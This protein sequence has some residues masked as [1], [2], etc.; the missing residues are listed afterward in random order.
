MP[1]YWNGGKSLVERR[2][3]SIYFT[4][5]SILAR[6]RLYQCRKFLSVKNVIIN[7]FFI[8]IF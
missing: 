3:V 8:A 6:A 5:D 7:C 1:F 2:F 4:F